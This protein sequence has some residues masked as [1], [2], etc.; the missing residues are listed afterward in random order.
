MREAIIGFLIGETKEEKKER[1]INGYC[2][3]CRIARK[4]VDC[5]RCS[6]NI[7]VID[8]GQ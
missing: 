1:A 2:N 8:N 6:K 7:E 4:D 3:A 5:R